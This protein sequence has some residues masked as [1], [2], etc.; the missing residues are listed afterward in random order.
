MKISTTGKYLGLDQCLALRV[1]LLCTDLTGHVR[2]RRL[3]E[4]LVRWLIPKVTRSQ[5]CSGGYTPLFGAGLHLKSTPYK[6]LKPD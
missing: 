1:T 6:W 2:T 4:R 5:L 3:V